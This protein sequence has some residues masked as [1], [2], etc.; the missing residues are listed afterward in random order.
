MDKQKRKE[1]LIKQF[2]PV[3]DRLGYK[4]NNDK[5]HVD[6][7]MKAEVDIEE[8]EGEAYCPCKIHTGEPKIDDKIIC[9]CIPFHKEEFDLNKKCWCGLFI[10]K[11]V[12]DGKDL[13]VEWKRP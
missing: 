10:K 6:F 5:E 11:E 1:E 12:K 9:P 8:K 4:W 2:T 3:I 13:S 7:L